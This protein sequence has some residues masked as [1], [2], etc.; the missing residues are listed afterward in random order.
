MPALA[1]TDHVCEITW[2]GVVPDIAASMR[3]VAHPSAEVGFD[4]IQGEDH[5][6]RTRTSCVRVASQHPEGTEIANVRQLTI[7]SEEELALIAAECE[8]DAINPIWLGASLIVKGIPDFTYIPPSSR[9][10]G[11]DGTT[12]VIDMVNL[13][14]VFPGR[15]I[16]KDMPGHGPK[17]KRAAVGRRG[18][19]A[20]VERPGTL[21]VGQS[22]RLH[23]PAQRAW[24]G[25][26]N[27]R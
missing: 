7:L 18:V 24:S 25:H 23:I 2:L 11:P 6:G 16:E 1:P 10:Q 27:D 12:L 17:F 9:L 8:L 3:S 14:C 20:W 21:A 13:P 5:A 22:M 19:T 15:E 4:G 26:T